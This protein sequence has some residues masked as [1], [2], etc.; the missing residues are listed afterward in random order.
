MRLF[1]N[2]SM[3]RVTATT[4]ALL[5][6]AG[7][8]MAG[9]VLPAR[10]DANTDIV[11]TNAAFTHT[12]SDGKPLKRDNVW[13]HDY[14]EFSVNYDATAA[15]PVPGDSFTVG[16]PKT[17]RLRDIDV[18]KP[19]LTSEGVTAGECSLTNPGGN[20]RITCVFNEAIK[21]K[22]D[23]KGSL[24]ASLYV[25]ETTATKSVDIDLGGKVAPVPLPYGKPIIKRPVAPWQARQEPA[26]YSEGVSSNSTAIT[27]IINVPG[28]WANANYAIGKPVMISDNLTPGVLFVSP[29]KS[30]TSLME[31][32]PKP[33]DPR[34]YV[35]R[36]VADSS[37]KSVDGFALGV[38][39]RQDH[40]VTL[41]G[42]GKWQDACEYHFRL[43]TTFADGSAIDKDVTYENSATFV[44]LDKTVKGTRR[45]MESFSGTIQYRDG[46]GGFK[47]AK[48][49]AGDDAEVVADKPYAFQFTCTDGQTGA[50]EVSAAGGAVVVHKQFREGTTCTITESGQERDGYTWS[51]ETSKDV[52]IVAG[53]ATE[54][55]FVNTY[56]KAAEPQGAP[57]APPQSPTDS[58]SPQPTPSV[59]DPA[60]AESQTPASPTPSRI[61]VRPGLPKTGR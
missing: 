5:M 3:R 18:S 7:G 48:S 56:A 49:V 4:T 34:G 57:P 33:E 28:S 10:A 42:T 52:T 17:L 31:Y 26:K 40:N 45:F 20:S 25:A 29:K 15:A 12:Y 59:A 30:A 55:K 11:F 21:G 22:I 16:L 8:L 35:A 24:K 27:W 43:Q 19:L 9:E 54:V 46:F 38:D 47:V 36:V 2:A 37:G 58:A 60:P 41:M 1:S 61:L 32:C 14:L 39:V 51:G 13:T 53:Q 44:G 6:A 50:L 23:V